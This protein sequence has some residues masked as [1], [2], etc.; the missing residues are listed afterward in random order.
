MSCIKIVDLAAEQIAQPIKKNK[1]K[2]GKRTH[3][4]AKIVLLLN[5]AVAQSFKTFFYP[6]IKVLRLTL[7]YWL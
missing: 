2:N 7:I 6:S 5:I 4:H 1:L 3:S